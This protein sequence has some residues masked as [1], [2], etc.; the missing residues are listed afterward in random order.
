[1]PPLATPVL[2]HQSHNGK[3]VYK[4][5]LSLLS[6]YEAVELFVTRA[7]QALPAFQMSAHNAHAIAQ[8]CVHLDGIPLAIELAAAR[9]GS[10]SVEEIVSR[11]DNR[12]RLLTRGSR[13]ALPRQQTLRALMDWSYNLLNDGEKALFCRLSVF[14]GGW[15]LQAA[16]EVC[17]AESLEGEEAFLAWEALDLLTSLVDNSLVMAT[18]EAEQTRYRL[19]ETV[20]QYAQDRLMESGETAAWRASHRNYFLRLAEAAAA[21]LKGPDQ[22]QWLQRLECEHDNLRAALDF[23][24]NTPEGAQSGLQLAGDLQQ[25]WLVR[26]YWSEG[27]NRLAAALNRPAAQAVTEERARALLGAGSLAWMEGDYADA[28]LL[29]E[30]ALELGRKLQNWRVV[31]GTLGNLG[32]LA[33]LQSDYTAARSCF[34]E[35]LAIKRELGDK[36][37]IANTLIGLGTVAME[38]GDY[39]SARLLGEESLA[40]GWELEDKQSIAR[41]LIN[42]GNV[43]HLQG[44]GAA[45]RACFEESLAIKRNLGDAR[46]IAYALIGLGNVAK[47][48]GNYA[49]A[50]SLFEESL[51]LQR[52]LGDREGMSIS[53]G[54]LGSL[55]NK[56]SD[57]SGAQA[58]LKECLGICRELGRKQMMAY[59]LEGYAE[60]A[61]RQQQTARS[62]RL[63]GAAYALRKAAGSALLPHECEEQERYL[64]ALRKAAGEDMFLAA[65]SDGQAMPLEQAIACALEE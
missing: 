58:C 63:Y 61:H 39:L 52:E 9:A 27:R 32:N 59:A 21:K 51:A 23:C 49:A 11:L 16:T 4:E 60:L 65:W 41:S 55:L 64:A 25:F 7:Q 45:A 17:A 44:E 26:G 24:L 34:E 13:A 29:Y 43:A 54:S 57:Y 37:D 53:L 42:L 62:A 56:Q 18:P 14:A 8:L 36:R 50:R 30:A 2:A 31:A 22:V 28:R 6:E 33:T 19:L 35:S 46:G 12:F 10:L 3:P 47:E 38:Q 1:M 48:Q 15:T 20:R 5:W 40:L